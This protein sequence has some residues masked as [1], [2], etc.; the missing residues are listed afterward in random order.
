MDK[1]IDKKLSLRNI[2]PTAMRALVLK[3]LTDENKALSLT[4]LEKKFETADKATLF[5]TL[6]TFEKNKLIHRIDD[7]SGAVRYA[8]CHD[9]CQ[10]SPQDLHVHFLCVKCNNTFCLHEIP[11]PTINLPVGFSME[12]VNM[13]VKGVC[14]NCTSME[15]GE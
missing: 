12:S 1:N 11:I 10:C 6:K 7:G 3:V 4:D 8:V 5:R 14:P 2:R 9:S 15:R 13:V